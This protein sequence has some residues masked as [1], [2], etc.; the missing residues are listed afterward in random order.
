MIRGDN[1]ILVNGIKLYSFASETE[2]LDFIDGKKQVLIAINAGKINRATPE[3]KEIINSGIGYADGLGAQY[4]L[5][6]G[7]FPNSV[8]IPGCELWL[9]IIDR[10]YQK[11]K[12][13]YL[14][15]GKRE[16]IDETIKKLELTYEHINICGYRDGYLKDGD[17]DELL[18]EIT[19]KKPDFVFVAMGSPKQELLI[20]KL[21]ERH[22]A[23]Y[24]GLGGS[25]DV[26]VGNVKRAPKW[27][28]EHNMEGPYRVISDFNKARWNRFINDLSFMI[29]LFFN[30]I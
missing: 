8:K 21:Y 18:T 24:Q 16:V 22:N 20:K 2:L 3:T 30:R 17:E 9:S 12:S 29:K 15:G 5:K 27:F 13:F 10:Y 23:V 4:A 25:F 7:G 6:K 19:T 11:G 1:Y 26:Y 28:R 14:I